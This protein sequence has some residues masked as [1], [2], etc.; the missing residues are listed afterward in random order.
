MSARFGDFVFSTVSTM[1]GPPLPPKHALLQCDA[2]DSCKVSRLIR[3]QDIDLEG[4]LK[5]NHKVWGDNAARKL[6]TISWRN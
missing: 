1:H 6:T 4:Q 2:R 3:V 5:H